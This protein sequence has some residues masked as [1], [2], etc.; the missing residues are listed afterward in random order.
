[1]FSEFAMTR[2]RRSVAYRMRS[3]EAKVGV[4]AARH[5]GMR[6]TIGINKSRVILTLKCVAPMSTA[7]ADQKE[8]ELGKAESAIRGS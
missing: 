6:L 5:R 3:L 4:S 2:V 7:I 8:G 1:M